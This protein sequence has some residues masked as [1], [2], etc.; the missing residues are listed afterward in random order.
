MTMKK[1]LDSGGDKM[2]L[3]SEGSDVM[4]HSVSDTSGLVS[5]S[6]FNKQNVR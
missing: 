6:M 2:L 5:R 4:H 1:I 3:D